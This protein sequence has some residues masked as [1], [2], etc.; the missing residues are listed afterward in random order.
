MCCRTFP[1]ETIPLRS[2][3]AGFRTFHVPDLELQVAQRA[4]FNATLQVGAPEQEF[5]LEAAATIVDA[6]RSPSGKH[7]G[8][9][10]YAID[11]GVSRI[12]L[13]LLQLRPTP[14]ADEA[15]VLASHRSARL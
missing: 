9:L 10:E 3:W 1:Q 6:T 2:G 13:A 11:D 15:R 14:P 8:C 12:Q 4:L 7:S 5:T